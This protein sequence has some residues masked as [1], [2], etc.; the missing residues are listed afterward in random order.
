MQRFRL[1]K[2]THCC[3]NCI[4]SSA[5]V[6]WTMTDTFEVGA[7]FPLEDLRA[8]WTTNPENAFPVIYIH[9]NIDQKDNQNICN[10]NESN[11][12]VQFKSC[13]LCLKNKC[14]TIWYHRHLLQPTW[15][16]QQMNRELFN[17]LILWLL[18]R[19]AP[20]FILTCNLLCVQSLEV[21]TTFISSKQILRRVFCKSF[22]T[23]QSLNLVS[24]QSQRDA[25]SRNLTVWDWSFQ[26]LFSLLMTSKI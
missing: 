20:F 8:S 14:H 16:D 7:F 2:F 4:L 9:W 3:S 6:Q 12:H 19:L 18:Q 5:A 23:V 17:H 15:Q 10:A 25:C 26:Q 22:C 11:A 13:P 24:E 21:F 1:E